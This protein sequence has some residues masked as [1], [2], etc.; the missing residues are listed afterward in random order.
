MKGYVLAAILAVTP[1]VANAENVV[2]KFNGVFGDDAEGLYQ[3]G[4]KFYG[5]LS[6]EREYNDDV[7]GLLGGWG[8]VDV[9]FE[10]GTSAGDNVN[11]ISGNTNTGSFSFTTSRSVPIISIFADAKGNEPHYLPTFQQLFGTKG[12]LSIYNARYDPYSDETLTGSGSGTL[13]FA[14]MAAPV[15]EPATWASMIAGLSLA[16]GVAGYRRRRKTKVTFA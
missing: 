14:P 8:M 9:F 15:P 3:P 6:Y 7:E 10:D 5:T 1:T 11:Y 4:E 2:L 13:T 16:G 12:G